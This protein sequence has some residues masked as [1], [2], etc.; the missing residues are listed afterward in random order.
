MSGRDLDD[1]ERVEKLCC[2]VVDGTAG[3]L[4]VSRELCVLRFSA[5]G[6]DLELF[7]PFVAVA[8]E[9]EDVPTPER[10]GLWSSA[11]LARLRKERDRYLL[12]VE[13]ELK[14]AAG[15]ILAGLGRGQVE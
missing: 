12:T 5:A 10:E 3:L 2:A 13:E 14:R 15:V 4:D 11:R 6:L 8:S 1:L 9:L 7:D